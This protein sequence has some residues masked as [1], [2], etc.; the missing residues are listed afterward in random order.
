MAVLK[1]LAE[2]PQNTCALRKL[3]TFIT[4]TVYLPPVAEQ[5]KALHNELAGFIDDELIT[6]GIT[7]LTP[8]PDF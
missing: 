1:N 7:Y 6:R 8:V 2:R 5:E 3:R 4:G